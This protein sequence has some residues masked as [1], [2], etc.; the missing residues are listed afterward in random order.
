VVTVQFTL[1]AL[2]NFFD[3]LRLASDDGDRSWP[4]RCHWNL[5]SATQVQLRSSCGFQIAPTS[6][7]L[8]FGQL[9]YIAV[10]GGLLHR[11]RPVDETLRGYLLRAG[12]AGVPL[13]GICTGSFVLCRLGLMTGRKCC[14]SWYHYHD[15]L[16]EF[17]AM[18]PVA[19]E[20]HVVDGDRITSSG[21]I[22][23]ALAAA[24]LVERHLDAGSAQKALRIMQI[25]RTR[26]T[27]ALQPAPPLTLPCDDKR[28][29]RA[30]LLMEQ[31]INSPIPIDEIA[32]RIQISRRHLE[33]V[34]ERQTGFAPR[35]MYM[36]LRLKH[37]R[38]ML[39]S[40]KSLAVV[41]EET[42]FANSSR[43][44]AALRRTYDTSSSEERAA[45]IRGVCKNR[46][47]ARVGSV[48]RMGSVVRQPEEPRGLR[49]DHLDT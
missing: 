36:E 5:M 35:T 2:A 45:R 18:V 1:N 13:V 24:H 46:A 15:F 40:C 29:T 49:Q 3:A 27:A 31:N 43:L 11:G 8:D 12:K 28:V 4:F 47:H 30:L 21:G 17:D 22:G 42:G 39:R 32:A 6:T 10:I 25:D 20:L 23:A 37:A 16:A 26:S 38:W 7:L 9:D 19:D 44:S 14:I 41:A 33:R 34:F 48:A